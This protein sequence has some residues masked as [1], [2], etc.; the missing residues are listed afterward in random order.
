MIEDDFDLQEAYIL[1]TEFCKMLLTIHAKSTSEVDVVRMLFSESYVCVYFE[2]LGIRLMSKVMQDLS[3]SKLDSVIDA[4]MEEE[5]FDA[6]KFPK[7]FVD[8]MERST[9]LATV[10]E[11][12][13]MA[14]TDKLLTISSKGISGELVDKIKFKDDFEYEGCVQVQAEYIKRV[15]DKVDAI[16]LTNNRRMLL[17]TDRKDF[18]YI[19]SCQN[20]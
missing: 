10:G 12:L 14:F 1:P 15:L 6:L 7:M 3:T 13:S 20:Q 16:Y 17:L 9:I 18:I 4:T 11:P 2:D 19:V 8:A 5:Y